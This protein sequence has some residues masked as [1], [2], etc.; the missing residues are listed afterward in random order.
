MKRLNEKGFSLIE[1][2][3][4]VAIIGV[5]SAIAIPNFQ[6]FQS[7]AKTSE[8]KTSLAA[9][10][11]AEKAFYAEWAQYMSDFRNIGYTPNGTYRYDHGFN[12]ASGDVA[13]ANYT[14]PGAAAGAASTQ[15]N[16]TLWGGAGCG[17]APTIT[18]G[19]AVVTTPIPPVDPL[20]T[21]VVVVGGANP[22]F[23]A[24]AN[25]NLNGTTAAG[26]ATTCTMGGAAAIA[27][28]GAGGDMDEWAIDNMNV[29]C[30]PNSAL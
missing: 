17:Q 20:A 3:I 8:A 13:P 26:S 25:A 28:T 18:N 6:K 19:C 2:M 29:L 7:K 14:G 10:Y 5:L 23:I 15:V 24:E 22:Y 9:I 16:T 30:N 4:V 11:T 21:A 1:L 12:A 27:V